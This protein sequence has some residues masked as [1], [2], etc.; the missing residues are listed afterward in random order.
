MR[1]QLMGF[2]EYAVPLHGNPDSTINAFCYYN[3]KITI[4]MARAKRS[5]MQEYYSGWAYFG[6]KWATLPFPSSINTIVCDLP[7]QICKTLAEGP[8]VGISVAAGVN[9]ISCDKHKI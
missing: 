4:I 9:A 2:Y 3:D 6:K 1:K 7:Q 5:T 8:T